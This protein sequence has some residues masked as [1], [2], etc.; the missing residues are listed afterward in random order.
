[1]FDALISKRP[2]KEKWS[3]ERAIDYLV[4]QKGKQFDPDVV[5]SFLS[6]YEDEMIMM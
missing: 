6:L 4:E 2:Y 1:V 3:A 5:D